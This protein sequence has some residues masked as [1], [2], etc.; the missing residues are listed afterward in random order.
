MIW[1]ILAGGT[2]GLGIALTAAAVLGSWLLFVVIAAPLALVG[3]M[4]GFLVEL[5]CDQQAI[6]R[7]PDRLAQE[8]DHLARA[9]E[10]RSAAAVLVRG[11][12]LVEDAANDSSTD[13]EKLRAL[14]A[15]WTALAKEYIEKD[16]Y[17]R[18]HRARR[19]R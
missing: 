4:F 14:A 18:L 13:T 6:T 9:G 15:R 19:R 2:I 16:V 3:A 10:F 17:L 1:T 12:V 11:A 7:D 5:W 8:A